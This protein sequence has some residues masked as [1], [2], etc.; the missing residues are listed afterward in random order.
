MSLDGIE[1]AFTSRVCLVQRGASNGAQN[2]LRAWHGHANCN[3][4]S[5][6]RGLPIC[7]ENTNHEG[8][9]SLITHMG[10]GV[11]EEQNARLLSQKRD[12]EGV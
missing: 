12:D 3:D 9:L 7:G 6:Q 10:K 4:S 5:I 1:L 8:T 11:R 2:R